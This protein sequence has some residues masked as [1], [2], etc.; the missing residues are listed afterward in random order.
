[1]CG[2][3]HLP[4]ARSHTKRKYGQTENAQNK[5]RQSKREANTQTNNQQRKMLR[6][7]GGIQ[8]RE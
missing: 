1:M 4:T 8:K 5:T 7:K 3:P 6:E 2:I